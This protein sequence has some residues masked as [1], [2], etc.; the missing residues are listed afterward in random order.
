[1]MYRTVR[2]FFA[3]SLLLLLAACGEGDW[4]LISGYRFVKTDATNG[5]IVDSEN[6]VIVEANVDNYVVIDP[7]IVGMRV[8]SDIVPPG[9]PT[10]PHYG[11]FLLDTR[12]GELV[13]GLSQPQVETELKSR[14][15][16]VPRL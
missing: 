12:T 7:Y 10:S 14:D 6:R 11:H 8:P 16:T 13:E 3:P 5:M 4:P 1:M 2:R 9:F 15:L